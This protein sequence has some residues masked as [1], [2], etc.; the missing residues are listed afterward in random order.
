[1]TG[2]AFSSPLIVVSYRWRGR[3]KWR[4]SWMV[5]WFV[6]RRHELTCL[7]CGKVQFAD[8][9]LGMSSSEQYV[10]MITDLC[11]PMALEH[12]G[13][14][15]RS[16]DEFRVKIRQRLASY[17]GDVGFEDVNPEAEVLK[18]FTGSVQLL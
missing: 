2:F 12:W 5:E 14:N 4:L 3:E 9:L 10:T 16:S 17:W 7:I 15:S 11:Y 6:T 18:A 8:T 13:G 1:L